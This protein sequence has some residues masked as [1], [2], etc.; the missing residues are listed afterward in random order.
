MLNVVITGANRGL[1]LEFAQ[2]YHARG[3]QLFALA[4]HNSE[5]LDGLISQGAKLI[6][7]DLTDE[8]VLSDIGQQLASVP[9]DI[10]INNAGIMGNSTFSA[11][12]KTTQGLH[13][14][15]R[16]EW[17][18]V[19][20][21]NVFTPAQLTATL[22]PNLNKGARVITVSSSMGSI[23]GNQYG[24]WSAYRASKA[25]VNS[26]MK[27]AALELAEREVVAVALHPGWVRTDMGGEQ[28]DIDAA[29]SVAGMIKV[30]DGLKAGDSGKFLGFDGRELPY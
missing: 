7:G 14:F 5:A 6:P 2:R 29:T 20:E 9:I 16:S 30:I 4:R 13:D 10:L 19:F 1:G 8:Q 23:S 25:A 15:D 24:G 11:S 21:A 12:G 28:A 26:L 17:Q 18:R 27:S 22:L 3:C